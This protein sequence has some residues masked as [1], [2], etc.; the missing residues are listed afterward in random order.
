MSREVSPKSLCVQVT[1][2]NTFVF[3]D[4]NLRYCEKW[5]KSWLTGAVENKT[6]TTFV[7]LH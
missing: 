3:I 6:C 7:D 4:D 5:L 2:G 1:G